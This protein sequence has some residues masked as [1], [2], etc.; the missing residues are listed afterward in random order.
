ME[1]FAADLDFVLFLGFRVAIV[2]FQDVIA[3]DT[4][5]AGLAGRGLGGAPFFFLHFMAQDS[6]ET[7]NAKL[8]EGAHLPGRDALSAIGRCELVRRDRGDGLGLRRTVDRA[9]RRAWE[10]R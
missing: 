4:D 3:G 7:N 6:V 2:G 9:Y 1:D 10:S 8:N 5:L